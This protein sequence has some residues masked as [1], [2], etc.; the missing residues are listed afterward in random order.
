MGEY[1]DHAGNAQRLA[2]VDAHD[3]PFWNSRF[4]YI[5]MDEAGNVELA[6]ISGFAGDLGPAVDAGCR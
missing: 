4:D 2:G 3:P 1:V 6:G 5:A